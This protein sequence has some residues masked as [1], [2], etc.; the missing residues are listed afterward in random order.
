[1]LGRLL[2]R[3]HELELLRS[4]SVI[5]VSTERCTLWPNQVILLLKESNFAPQFALPVCF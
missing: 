5:H 4:Q 1:M 2:H 3:L